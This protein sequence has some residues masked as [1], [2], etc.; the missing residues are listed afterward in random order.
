MRF[1]SSLFYDQEAIQTEL[2]ETT[3]LPDRSEQQEMGCSERF[4][5]S[6][7]GHRAASRSEHAQ[8]A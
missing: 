4:D 5:S 1:D 8:I 2:Q 7:E 3:A 6:E